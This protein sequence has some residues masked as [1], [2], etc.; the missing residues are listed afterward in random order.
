[1]RHWQ[2][3]PLSRGRLKSKKTWLDHLKVRGIGCSVQES[4]TLLLKAT[5]L[6][7]EGLEFRAEGL[8]QLTSAGPEE[9]LSSMVHIKR[10]STNTRRNLHAPKP[11]CL[12]LQP[13]KQTLKSPPRTGRVKT[14]QPSSG[15][16]P[17]SPNRIQQRQE[18]ARP[19]PNPLSLWKG[20]QGL[21][22]DLGPKISRPKPDRRESLPV[23][24]Q[25]N[26]AIQALIQTTKDSPPCPTPSP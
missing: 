4:W 1:M 16:E 5:S 25:L 3:S 10:L 2:A 12:G 8:Q 13:N 23:A 20:A 21:E 15:P 11:R 9:H 19:G 6:G 22:S 18:D 17:R 26:S 7:L 14:T 24:L